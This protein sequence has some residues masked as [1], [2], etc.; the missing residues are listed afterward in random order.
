MIVRDGD[1][2]IEINRADLIG[3]TFIHR[4]GKKSNLTLVQEFEDTDLIEL[5]TDCFR[6]VNYAHIRKSNKRRKRK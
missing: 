1:Y 2:L 5:I 3:R 6:V 4:K